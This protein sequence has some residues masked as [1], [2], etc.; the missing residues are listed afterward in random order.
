MVAAVDDDDDDE[1]GGN[2]NVSDGDDD[3]G[4]KQVA[5][6][7]ERVR[8]ERIS[9]GAMKAVHDAVCRYLVRCWRERARWYGGVPYRGNGGVLTVEPDL[10][11]SLRCLR[12][13][14][15]Q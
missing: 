8:G 3:E 10:W 11:E 13:G 2:N 9:K 14:A 15:E 5:D 6:D 1:E 7:A 4:G 12:R